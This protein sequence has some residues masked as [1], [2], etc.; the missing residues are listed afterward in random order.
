MERILKVN[1]EYRRPTLTGMEGQLLSCNMEL[2][3]DY[4]AV[5]RKSYAKSHVVSLYRESLKFTIRLQG[6]GIALTSIGVEDVIAYC[7]TIE[8]SSEV[9]L[10]QRLGYLRIFM[11][12][13]VETLGLPAA[14]EL[15]ADKRILKRIILVKNCDVDQM[16]MWREATRDANTVIDAEKMHEIAAD[17]LEKYAAF[18]YSRSQIR[19]ARATLDSLYVFLL[20]NKAQYCRRA[21]MFWEQITDTG[22]RSCD[23][24]T[25]RTL[26]LFDIFLQTGKV[27][28]SAMQVRR[29]ALIN[30]MPQ[31]CLDVLSA[32]LDEIEQERL[33]LRSIKMY[34][35]CCIRFI[36]FAEAQGVGDWSEIDASL[37]N[38]FYLEDRH[39]TV[40]GKNAFCSR[41]RRF[42]DYLADAGLCRA[43]LSKLLPGSRAISSN[44]VESLSDEDLRRIE[45]FRRS[46][47]TPLELRDAAIA[48]LGLR[49]GLRGTDIVRLNLD[50]IDW[51]VPTAT[52][53]QSKTSAQITVPLT[54]D[55]ANSVYLYIVK[56][57]PASDARTVFVQH[58]APYRA[59][60]RS[61][62]G[63][64]LARILDNPKRTGFH[65]TRKTF[66]SAMMAA[67]VPVDVIADA[68]G[69]STMDTVSKYLSKNESKMRECAI[70][71]SAVP[72]SEGALL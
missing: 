4:Y 65:I 50:D 29:D 19:A 28:V 6:R 43:G 56:G 70:P 40:E 48:M 67:S 5:L 24:R 18:G 47:S 37:V 52:L 41:V 30:Q 10:A 17:F 61:A 14:F 72:L 11:N 16:K 68:L 13:L 64:A 53:V 15:A 23:G 58:R 8:S 2:L 25:R 3:D 33:A 69:H 49:T 57:R 44:V 21:S 7:R 36:R 1:G 55:A 59:L 42:L 31:W 51:S 35:N 46:A 9:V 22:E 60:T 26:F 62:C 38:G 12:F 63:A 27:D 32:F 45:T 71:L 39:S 34:K 54:V 66:A 20:A